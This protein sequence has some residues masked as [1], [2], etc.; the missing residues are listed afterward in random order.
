MYKRQVLTQLVCVNGVN[1]LT[2]RVSSL[3]VSLILVVRKA[4]SL[5]ISVIVMNNDSG[6]M[7][8]WIGAAG[9]LIGTVGYTYGGMQSARKKTD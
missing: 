9:V 4:V 6:S 3:S 7:W 5:I 8:L 2:A 1:R